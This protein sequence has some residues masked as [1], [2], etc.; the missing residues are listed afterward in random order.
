MENK[1]KAPFFIVG[2]GRSGTTL[3]RTLLENH[4]RIGIPP[5]GHIFSRFSKLFP[6]YGDLSQEVN[7]KRFV[8]DLFADAYVSQFDFGLSEEVFYHRLKERSLR[9][10]IELLFEIHLEKDDKDHWGDK[11]PS[12]VHHL[13]KIKEVFP[14]AKIIH[15][16]RD[17][18]DVAESLERVWFSPQNI[19]DNAII[20]KQRVSAFQEAKEWLP[21]GDYLEVCYE[22]LAANPDEEMVRVFMF[23]GEV[24]V[25]TNG[26][27]PETRSIQILSRAKDGLHSMLSEPISTKKVGIYKKTFTPRQ[28]ALFESIAGDTLKGYGYTL[29][30]DGKARITI[31]EKIERFFSGI[32]YRIVKRMK[33]PFF[34][35]ERFQSRMRKLRLRL[36]L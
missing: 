1:K 23:L 24:P 14:E 28:I 34:V 22:T 3:L 21:E 7:C 5:E 16:F 30:T 33:E 35:K 18:R 32:K 6:L 19:I 11:T 15:L 27:I 17:G 31:A 20:W 25:T 13:Q 4:P 10:C 12:H 36:G 8:R 2:C 29:E 9:N 26:M